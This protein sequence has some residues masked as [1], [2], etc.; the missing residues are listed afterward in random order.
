MKQGA[1]DSLSMAIDSWL[2]K[3]IDT[4]ASTF[5]IDYKNFN[6]LVSA[7]REILKA[8]AGNLVQFWDDASQSFTGQAYGGIDLSGGADSEYY[9]KYTKKAQ[10]ILDIRD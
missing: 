8:F 1:N 6:D 7:K 10:G 3:Y 9:E 2:S 4:T 5:E